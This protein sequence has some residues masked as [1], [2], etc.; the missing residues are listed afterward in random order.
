MSMQPHPYADPVLEQVREAIA[1]LSPLQLDSTAIDPD[2]SLLELGMDSLR[3]VDLTVELEDRLHVREF[4][5]QD[6]ADEEAH[7]EGQ[8]YTVRSLATAFSALV[9]SREL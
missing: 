3:I 7:V 6:W 9:H 8:Q 1:E 4:P 5:I 2:A